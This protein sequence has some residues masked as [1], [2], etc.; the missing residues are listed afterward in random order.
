MDENK[1]R[2]MLTA[3]LTEVANQAKADAK[4][5]QS[6]IGSVFDRDTPAMK[7]LD[8]KKIQEAIADIKRA[9]ATKESC[10]RLI[11]TILLAAKAIAIT[12]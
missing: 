2:D 11:N 9:T 7:M 10:A 8:E 12:V 4:A 1:V 5:G 3:F 6:N